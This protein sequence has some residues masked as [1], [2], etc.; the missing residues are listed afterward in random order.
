M[1]LIISHLVEFAAMQVLTG[2]VNVIYVMFK[3]FHITCAC[4][5]SE[6]MTSTLIPSYI[7]SWNNSFA[8]SLDWTNINMGGLKPCRKIN[9]DGDKS[10][11]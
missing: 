5:L 9:K 10:C 3:T 8:L 1:N 4:V 7:S 2:S 11:Q 6:W